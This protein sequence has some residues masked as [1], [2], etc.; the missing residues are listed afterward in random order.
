MRSSPRTA[1]R[2]AGVDV[3]SL[4]AVA[5][6]GRVETD[7]AVSE[8]R[9]FSW[10]V[11]RQARLDNELRGGRVFL[12]DA[13]GFDADRGFVKVLPDV[14]RRRVEPLGQRDDVA[15]GISGDGFGG[16]DLRRV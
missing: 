8:H 6:G 1:R 11:P 13:V 14:R 3:T 15:R 7:L 12:P 16:F 10:I 2:P 4:P 9:A 5:E